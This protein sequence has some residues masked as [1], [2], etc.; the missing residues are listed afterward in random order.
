[1]ADVLDEQMQFADR[2]GTICTR[3]RKQ[4]DSATLVTADALY[5]TIAAIRLV[6]RRSKQQSEALHPALAP[7]IAVLVERMP[8][9]WVRFARL[10]EEEWLKCDDALHQCVTGAGE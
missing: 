9:E 5:Y 2:L 4:I 1:M 3:Y 7:L 6:E 10:P 8:A